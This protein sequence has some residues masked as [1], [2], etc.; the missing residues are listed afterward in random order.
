MAKTKETEFDNM[1]DFTLHLLLWFFLPGMVTNFVQRAYYALRYARGS[2][3]RP[4]PGSPRHKRD[5]DRC[6]VF[7]ISIYLFYCIFSTIYMMPPNYYQDFGVPATASEKV[8]KAQFRKYSLMY[9]P[10]RNPGPEAEGQFLRL[11]KIYESLTNPV[12]KEAYNKFGSHLTCNGCILFKDYLWNGLMHFI[13][14][15]GGVGFALIVLNTLGANQVG[16]YWRFMAFLGMMCLEA[17]MILLPYD[18]IAWFLPN[19]TIAEKISVLRHSITY[20]FMAINQFG[21]ALFPKET[22]DLRDS[23][24]KVEKQAIVNELDSIKYFEHH[25]KP[26]IQDKSKFDLLKIEVSRKIMHARLFDN[27]ADYRN[28]TNEFIA[29]RKKIQ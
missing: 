20:I 25:L 26:F 29:K 23:L 1:G 14:F 10:D 4:S 28:I 19:A 27:D 17:A 16:T 12:L 3:Y 22:A 6:Y 8:L 7:V 24:K 21:P 13:G 2:I 15:Y 5:Y 11:R 18:P 9:H